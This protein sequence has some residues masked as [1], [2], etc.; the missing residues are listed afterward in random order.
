[1][2]I[3]ITD[4]KINMPNNLLQQSKLSITVLLI[5]VLTSALPCLAGKY[6]FAHN[7]TGNQLEHFHN[8]STIFGFLTS[9]TVLLKICLAACTCIILLWASIALRYLPNCA[10]YSRAPPNYMGFYPLYKPFF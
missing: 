2:T 4:K 6:D 1:M 9:P 10:T 5:S 3:V 7:H 8:S